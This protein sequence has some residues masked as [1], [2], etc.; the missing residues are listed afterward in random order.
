LARE[1]VERSERL[2]EGL[3][4][5]RDEQIGEAIYKL[6]FTSRKEATEKSTADWALH[7][8]YWCQESNPT[9]LIDY[10]LEGP[11][12]IAGH[13]AYQKAGKDY[14]T[15]Y[16]SKI[17]DQVRQVEGPAVAAILRDIIPKPL[18]RQRIRA[19]RSWLTAT[20]LQLA[21]WI[22]Q[23]RAFDTMPILA[24]ALED[25]GCTNADI[26]QHLRSPGPHVLGCWPLDLVLGK[27]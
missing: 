22:Y 16:D 27:S 11:S 4:G 1:A 24:D 18:A 23:E 14:R 25:A 5:E 21:E 3:P 7:A 9:V 13:I 2:A 19:Q 12:V 15:D 6:Y 8:A 20:V 10:V 26:L 17:N